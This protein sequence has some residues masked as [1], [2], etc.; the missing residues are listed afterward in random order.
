MYAAT[1]ALYHDQVGSNL[2]PI[3]EK[4]NIYTQAFNWHE[5]DFPAS[6][7]N[8]AIFEIFH[9]NK[10]DLRRGATYIESP[11]CLKPI[12]ATTNPKILMMF[13]V[14]CMLQ[15]QPLHFIMTN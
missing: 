12:K 6:Y 14:L 5:I 13:I 3:T 2:E 4:L 1:N 7:E 11:K 9:F 8:Y 10:I 15:P